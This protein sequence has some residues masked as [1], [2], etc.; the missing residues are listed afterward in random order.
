MEKI[1]AKHITDKRFI[2]IILLGKLSRKMGKRYINSQFTE[3]EIRDQKTFLKILNLTR[4]K[5]NSN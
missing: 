2:E 5:K 3:K 1:L 4:N